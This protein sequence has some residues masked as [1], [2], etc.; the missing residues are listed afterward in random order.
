MTENIPNYQPL[1]DIEIIEHLNWQLDVNAALAKL[2][3]FLS[4]PESTIEDITHIILQQGK[5]L[6]ESEHGFVS[7]ID[8]QTKDNI[9]YTLTAM[10]EKECRLVGENQRI[11]FPPD[12]NGHYPGLWGHALNTHKPFYTNAPHTHPAYLSVPV[13]HVPLE[14]FLAFPVLLGNELAG[15]IALA[16]PRNDYTDRDLM[17]VQRL[18]EFFTLAIQRKRTTDILRISEEKYRKLFED[19]IDGIVLADA[20]TGEILDCNTAVCLLVEREKH[21]LVGQFQGILYPPLDSKNRVPGFFYLMQTYE[22]EAPRVIETQVVTRTG[23]IRDVAIKANLLEL[24]GRKVLQEMLRDITEKKQAEK[25]LEKYR[26]H[27][28]ELVRERAVELS[29]AHERLRQSQKIEAIGTL[30]GGIAHDFN[31]ILGVIIGYTELI[32]D[33]LPPGSIAKNN[34]T[35]VLTAAHRAKEMVNKLLTFSKKTKAERRLVHFNEI[36]KD[37]VEFLKSTLPSS[38]KILV[39]MEKKPAPVMANPAQILQIIL[40]IGN[41]AI[42][43]MKDRGGVLKIELNE[44]IRHLSETDG[45]A[46]G[47]YQHLIISDTGHGMGPEILKRIFEPFFTSKNVG[48]GTGMGLAVVHGIVEGHGGG[49]TVNSEP[50]KGTVVHVY[51]PVG[52]PHL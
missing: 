41:N 14:R 42:Y 39:T 51:L 23:K 27:L 7:L 50:G 19:A 43:A 15:L 20:Q 49:I 33:D 30:A 36:I 18:A 46:P 45:L 3:K 22:K 48:E 31:N 26:E 10:L 29:A 5:I 32:D 44:I 17:A 25:D 16:N 38:I 37:A 28:E 47:K 1:N 12:K 34:V 52:S 21:E 35:H 24:G 11:I 9:G 2:Y 8:P 40:N 4:S 6:T 13:G